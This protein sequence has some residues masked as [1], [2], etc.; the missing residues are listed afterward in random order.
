MPDTTTDKLI[1]EHLF[2][3]LTPERRQRIE[4]VLKNRT[5]YISV[6]LE[7][8]YQPHNASAVIRSCD[9][10]GIQDLHVIENGNEFST[11]RNVTKGSS[12]W[13]DLH[14]HNQ[15][16][17]NTK[18]CLQSLKDN[19]YRIIATSPHSKSSSLMDVD[20]T[21]GKMAVVFGTE[22]TGISDEVREMA[23]EYLYIPLYGFTESFNI[24]VSAAMCLQN[25]YE[26]TRNTPELDWQLSEQEK[27]AIKLKWARQII[28]KSETLEENFLSKLS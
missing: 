18:S 14:T 17:N 6:V 11:S 2:E 20:V 19:G 26:S 16:A 28:R 24:S 22:L 15:E 23:D 9:C 7:N 10:F 1:Q 8:I 5:R 13:V 27:D 12:R 25:L 4:D 3:F 21:K